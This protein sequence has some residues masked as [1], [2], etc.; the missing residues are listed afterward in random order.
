[1][2]PL[3]SIGVSLA[4]AWP[5]NA[6]HAQTL[7]PSSPWTLEG[8]EER[9]SLLRNFG[10]GENQVQLQIDSFGRLDKVLVTLVGEPV[11]RAMTVRGEVRYGFDAD[12][13]PRAS[14]PTTQGVNN[15]LEFAQ[16]EPTFRP[17]DGPPDTANRVTAE[18]FASAAQVEAPDP[19][20]ESRIRILK[21]DFGRG[22]DFE[23]AIGNM[24]QPLAVLRECLAEL[25]NH[26]GLDPAQQK[27]LAR[28]PVPSIGAVRGIMANYPEVM[29]SEGVNAYIPVRVMVDA[30]GTPSGCHA[31]LPGVES[32]F[33]T[34]ICGGLNRGFEPALDQ[35]GNALASFYQVH[36]LYTMD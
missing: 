17:Y 16:F 28:Y 11:P 6:A 1:M 36:V 22:S 10:S 25:H 5:A 7:E 18:R 14:L 8:S 9:C 24:A 4:L 31:Q 20:F 23:L 30:T 34:K 29:A 15:G 19:E 32:D 2:R 3:L 27:L 12:T 13:A 33:V 21:I 26:W 35:A